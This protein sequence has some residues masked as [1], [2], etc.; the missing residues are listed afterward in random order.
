MCAADTR[1]CQNLKKDFQMHI[2]PKAFTRQALVFAALLIVNGVNHCYAGAITA[3]PGV[4][5]GQQFRIIFVTPNKT[6]ATSSDITDYDDFVN[7]EAAGA[8]YKGATIQWQ[9]LASTNTVNARDHVGQT[10][11]AVYMAD[12]TKV[13]DSDTTAAGGLWNVD[14]LSAQPDQDLDGN[15]YVGLVW[16]GTSGV[17]T[18]YETTPTPGTPVKWG[19]GST[20]FENNN[21]SETG[22][23]P[24]TIG[25]YDWISI[26]AG[27]KPNTD[28]YQIYGISE[29]ITAIPEPSSFLMSGLGMLVVGLATK[30]RK[31]NAV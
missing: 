29:V 16:T 24:G 6:A 18:T 17:G 31:R 2:S 7:A 12:G 19:L 14:P 20:G 5:G 28:L 11:T 8:T 10:G 4:F 21:N 22:N 3:P 25:G 13:A 27:V 1:T 30:F 23:V 15:S 26:P 9:A